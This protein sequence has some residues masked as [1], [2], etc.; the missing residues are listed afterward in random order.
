MSCVIASVIVAPC[1]TLNRYELD[2]EDFSQLKVIEGLNVDYKCVPDSA[3]KAVFTTTADKA[4]VLMFS[5]KKGR[6]DLQISTD[7]IAYHNLPTITVYSNFLTSVENSGD[8][9]VR[10]LSISPGPALKATL[11]GNGRLVVHDVNST[12]VDASLKTG[13]GQ[14]VLDGKCV[15]AHLGVVGTGTIQA[16]RLNAQE[17]KCR[18][19]G[20]GSIGCDAVNSLIILGGSVGPGKIY[21]AGSPDISTK[22]FARSTA[23]PLQSIEQKDGE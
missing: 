2:V 18:I 4:S 16:D 5:N 7:G 13:N 3:G 1:E 14:L 6:L 12:R 17:V 22:P 8:S 19:V 10:V 23:V 20:T 21:Y 11:I 15:N 9:T